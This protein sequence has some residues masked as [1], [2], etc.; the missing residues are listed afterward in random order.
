M[1]ETQRGTCWEVNEQAP[2]IQKDNIDIPKNNLNCF[3]K[4]LCNKQ[5]SLY[6]INIKQIL[7]NIKTNS[8][9]ASYIKKLNNEDS[10]LIVWIGIKILKINYSYTFKQ[11]NE[12]TN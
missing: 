9:K 8:E 10:S 1:S 4:N 3:H 7:A 12:G 11:W 5:V 2:N 6:I